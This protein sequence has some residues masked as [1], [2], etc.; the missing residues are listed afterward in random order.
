MCLVLILGHIYLSAPCFCSLSYWEHP[1][2]MAIRWC[3]LL[4]YFFIS[5]VFIQ[6]NGFINQSKKK[7]LQLCCFL[8]MHLISCDDMEGLV[9]EEVV[10]SKHNIATSWGNYRWIGSISIASEK[11]RVEGQRKVDWLWLNCCWHWLRSTWDSLSHALNF[12]I[13]LETFHKTFYDLSLYF[14]ML[15]MPCDIICVMQFFKFPR[16]WHN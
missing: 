13:S 2:S 11:P 15:E 7:L 3:C 14:W 12:C 1:H 5:R 8:R 6:M 4:K 10:V 9:S 16:S